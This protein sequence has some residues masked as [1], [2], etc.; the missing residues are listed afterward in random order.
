[1][2]RRF[3]P[4]RSGWGCFLMVLLIVLLGASL[5]WF[6]LWGRAIPKAVEDSQAKTSTSENR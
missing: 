3:A 5:V 4:K 2:K 6:V 1:M